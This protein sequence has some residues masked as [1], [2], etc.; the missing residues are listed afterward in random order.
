LTTKERED[1]LLAVAAAL[2]ARQEEILA[3]NAVDVSVAESR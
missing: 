2:Q 3:A 1:I